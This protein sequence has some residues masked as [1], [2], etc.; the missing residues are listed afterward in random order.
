MDKNK[1]RIIRLFIFW[2]TMSVSFTVV[3]CGIINVHGLF[4]EI[5]SSVAT[6]D[7]DGE[8]FELKSVYYEKICKAKGINIINVWFE[9]LI[10]IV[11]ISFC[12]H[13]VKLPR[14]DTI[15]TLKVRMDN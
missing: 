11:S 9:I 8:K 7:K 5:I 2:F 1:Q 12:A 13:L 4:G 15:V 3:P 6:E 14:G 10:A